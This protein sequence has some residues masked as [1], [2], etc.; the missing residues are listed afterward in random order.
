M[1]KQQ[2]LVMFLL[3]LAEISL[4]APT[5]MKVHGDWPIVMPCMKEAII[6]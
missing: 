2:G 1:H 3:T 4:C 6:S 5:L